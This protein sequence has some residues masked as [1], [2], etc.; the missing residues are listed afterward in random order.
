MTVK[1]ERYLTTRCLLVWCLIF[2]WLTANSNAARASKPGAVNKINCWKVRQKNRWGQY[3]VCINNKAIRIDGSSGGVLLSCAPKWDILM[4]HKRDRKLSQVP[5]SQWIK[6]SG[7]RVYLLKLKQKPKSAKVC[8]IDVETFRFPMHKMLDVTAGTSTL[9]RSKTS[10]H[11]VKNSYMSFDSNQKRFD[12]I[13]KL[14][15]NSFLE[16]PDSDRIVLDCYF[17]H[18]DGSRTSIIETTDQRYEKLPESFF[19]LPGGLKSTNEPPLSVYM[20]TG[21]LDAAELL[22]DTNKK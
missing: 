14:I 10:E 11:F 4:F 9:Y 1:P 3:V 16:L 18:K 17:E 12:R 21:L 13:P 7:G 5:F 15:L 22:F 6:K 19:K 20:G 2:T 8:G